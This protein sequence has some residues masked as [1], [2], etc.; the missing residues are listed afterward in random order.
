MRYFLNVRTVDAL[1][2]DDEG[3]EF[4]DLGGVCLYALEVASELARE[5]PQPPVHRS[6]ILPLALEVMDES[7][8]LVFRAPIH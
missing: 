8:N 6:T 3:K 5:Y 2:V 4:S 1:L 7:G